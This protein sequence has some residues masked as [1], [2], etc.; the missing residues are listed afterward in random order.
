VGCHAYVF[1]PLY[2]EHDLPGHPEN[3]TRLDTIL[4]A[5]RDEGLLPRLTLLQ[6]RPVSRA[7]LERVHQPGYVTAVQAMAARGGGY[8]D[9]DTY[10]TPR[11]F[12]AALLAAGGVVEL[13]HAVLDGRADN[14]IALIRPPGHHATPARGMGFCLFNNVALGAQAALERGLT[15]ILIVDWDVHHGNGTQEIFYRSPQVLYFSTHQYPHY[16]GTGH[17]REVGEGPG[18]GFTVNVP[19]PAGVGDQGFARIFAELLTPLARRFQPE[20]ILVSAGYDAHWSDPLAGLRLSLAGYWRMAQGVVN[21]AQELC[22]G[23]L[24]VALEGGYNLAIL[25]RAVADTCRALLGDKEPGPDPLGPCPWAEQP[26]DNLIQAVAAL[27]GL[28]DEG[29]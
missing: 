12:E 24:V 4:Q 21:L 26:A 16:P 22:Q 15:R 27:H 17:W 7:L 3:R 8:L 1:D 29:A 18:R 13:V 19:L 9:P 10:V 14:G 25:G 11:S 28:Q 23:R 20:V 6:P 2:L 5:L